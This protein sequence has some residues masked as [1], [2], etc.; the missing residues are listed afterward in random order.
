MRSR[1]LH[2]QECNRLRR[3]VV[4][5]AACAGA[6]VSASFSHVRR[7]NSRWLLSF[8]AA[9]SCAC[10]ITV[11]SAFGQVVEE[12]PAPLIFGE[13][14]YGLGPD[15]ILTDGDD[16]AIGVDLRKIVIVNEHSGEPASQ[17]WDRAGVDLSAAGGKLQTAAFQKR[18]EAFV[19]K[20]LSQRLLNEIRVEI[21]KQYRSLSRPFVSVAA[22]E[23]EVTNGVLRLNVI[24]FKAGEITTEGNV[25]TSDDYL[26]KRV[27][28]SAGEEIDAAKLVEDINWLN[29]N[30]YRSLGAVFESGAAPSAT[31]IVLRS[32]E[33][34]PWTV[35]AG[36]ARSGTASSRR[37]RVFA[38]ANMANLPLQDHQIS[39]LTTLNPDSLGEGDVVHV[40]HAPGY[41]SHALSYFAPIDVPGVVRTKFQLTA[42]YVESGSVLN[43]FF[44][45]FSRSWAIT[46][47]FAFPVSMPG[48]RQFDLF[49]GFDAKR[50]FSDVEFGGVVVSESNGDVG[51]FRIGAR[52]RYGFSVG[53]LDTQGSIEAY[54]ALS[55]SGI[56]ADS[57][58]YAY[59]YASFEQITRVNEG[60]GVLFSV[61][62]Q[63]TDDTLPDLEKIAIGGDGTVRGYFTNELS[64]NDGV[65]GSL[66]ARTPVVRHDFESGLNLA[67]EG[68]AFYD[69]GYV[70]NQGDADRGLQSLGAG[71]NL[72]LDEYVTATFEAARALKAAPDTE[73]GETSIFVSVVIR[74]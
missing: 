23:Q 9:A 41:A 59:F 15:A 21:I 61:A 29:L 4:T 28:Q 11:D 57:N 74:Y 40:T 38:G 34:R 71:V 72:A 65:Y 2:R 68:Y 13:Q 6:P 69:A 45:E 39:I 24:E 43:S 30:P 18:M 60:F 16:T 62:G 8:I 12:N 31:D 5:V 1:S 73:K 25:R 49:A 20:P 47:E 42:G 27:R 32:Q 36:Y 67:A 22:P 26:L 44:E 52:G 35:Y 48:T 19:G 7:L 14:R 10:L 63:A 56:I 3:N 54:A 58:N 17:S 51:Q 55:P 50:Q 66:E 46:S 70:W 37:D 64:G 53:Q 33:R